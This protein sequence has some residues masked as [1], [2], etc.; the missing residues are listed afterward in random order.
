MIRNAGIL[1]SDTSKDAAL[2]QIE[3]LQNMGLEGRARLTFQLCDNL[4]EVTKAGIRHRH[5]DYTDRQVTQAYL[6]LIC[7]KELFQ[8]IFPG[9]EIAV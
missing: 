9:C 5:P 6:R 3:V 7:D 8:E 1:P 4:R 2:K